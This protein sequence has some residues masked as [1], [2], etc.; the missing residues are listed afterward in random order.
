MENCNHINEWEELSEYHK[1]VWISKAIKKAQRGD[2]TELD[3]ALDCIDF[4]FLFFLTNLTSLLI[5][6]SLELA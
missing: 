6:G 3:Q 4:L 5:S 1:L 2:I